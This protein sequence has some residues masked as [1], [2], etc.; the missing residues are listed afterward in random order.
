MYTWVNEDTWE[1]MNNCF[2]DANQI[3]KCPK[4]V[5]CK[6]F[7]Y[8]QKDINENDEKIDPPADTGQ[9]FFSSYLLKNLIIQ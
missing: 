7:T 6:E 5:S 8:L 3:N 4:T 1:M 2:T 9:T